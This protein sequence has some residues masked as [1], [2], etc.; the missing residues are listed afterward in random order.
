MRDAHGWGACLTLAG[1]CG[2]ESVWRGGA[3]R[4][5]AHAYACAPSKATCIG[6]AKE[7][8]TTNAVIAMSQSVRMNESGCTTGSRD[9]VSPRH[10]RT[11][12]APPFP[13]STTHAAP[14]TVKGTTGSA[15]A[16]ASTAAHL[17]R[18]RAA[19]CILLSGCVV[20]RRV[21]G[22]GGARQRVWAA[23]AG[24]ARG[25]AHTFDGVHHVH[26]EQVL[27]RATVYR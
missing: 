9:H 22:E 16:T 10:A 4:G 7:V 1:G 3:E 25:R 2:Y 13:V 20:R 17:R 6:T 26:R 12:A 5:C 24:A 14:S 15:T 23:R 18:S 21:G 27:E 8:R 11:V 19:P